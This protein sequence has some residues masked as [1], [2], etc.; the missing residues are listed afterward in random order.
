MLC[1]SSLIIYSLIFS[2]ALASYFRKVFF[3]FICFA[4]IHYVRYADTALR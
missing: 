3:V 2:F 1:F 4:P